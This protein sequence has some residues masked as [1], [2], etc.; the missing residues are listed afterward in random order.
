MLV[1]NGDDF[2]EGKMFYLHK[3]LQHDWHSYSLRVEAVFHTNQIIFF[4]NPA[5]H[6]TLLV[7][8]S[9]FQTLASL[10]SFTLLLRWF[11]SVWLSLAIWPGFP[12]MFL[13]RSLPAM[14][15]HGFPPGF[16]GE[17]T[18][19]MPTSPLASSRAVNDQAWGSL[20][21]LVCPA[22]LTYFMNSFLSLLDV[23]QI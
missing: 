2:N 11:Y 8:L 15:P 18:L 14:L 10:W 9:N 16:Q 17:F 6:S 7:L 1:K 13:L 5:A 22:V 23:P 21:G 20:G 12:L 3:F 19:C 4:S